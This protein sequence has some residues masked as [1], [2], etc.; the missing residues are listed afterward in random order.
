M[1]SNRLRH[2]VTAALA[3]ALAGGGR[4][5]GP[6]F[7]PDDPIQIDRD[8][9]FDASGAQPYELSEG[10]DFIENSF[11][12]PAAG[13]KIRALNVNT[14]DEVPDSSWFT[15]R[16]GRR[17]LS[18]AEIARGPDLVE[19]LDVSEWLIVRDKGPAGFQPGFRAVDAQ[20]PERMFQLEVDLEKYP[21]FASSAELIGTKLY[22][23]I[24]YN[25]VDVYLLNVDRKDIRIAPTATMR[26]GTGRRS[27]RE[28]DLEDILKLAA[29]NED[30]TYRMTAGRFVEGQPMGNFKY[31]GTRPDDPNDIHPHEDRRELRAN[32]VFAAWLN[33]DDSRALNTLDM[34]VTEGNRKWIRHYMFDFGSMLGDTADRR[35]SGHSYLFEGRTLLGELLTFGLWVPPWHRI[36]YADDLRNTVGLLEGDA[37]DPAKWKP[38]YPNRAFEKMRADDAFWAARIVSRFSDEAIRAVVA[39]AQYRNRAAADY[40]EATIIKRRDKVLNTWLTGVNPIV[41][42][43]LDAAGALTFENA[44]QTARVASAPAEYVLRWSRFDNAA[45]GVVG[46]TVEVRAKEPR[47]SAPPSLLQGS[48]FLRVAIETLHPDHPHWKQPVHVYFRRGSGGWQTVGID[49]IP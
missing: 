5:A 45:D 39:K 17:E 4:A 31:Y 32:R 9:A 27:F 15:N 19:P 8:S 2:V 1:S 22:H 10:A 37:F 28:S 38:E 42:P 34:L 12:A 47:S 35:A 16:I 20:H 24:G 25:V 18:V 7:Y 48:D 49:R 41:D 33:H 11:G 21:D 6:R 29:R 23:A 14:V 44:A 46:P 36:D 43:R 30:G 3:L 40:V 26:D 13:D